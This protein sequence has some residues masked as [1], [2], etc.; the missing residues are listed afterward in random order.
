MKYTMNFIDMDHIDSNDRYSRT[1]FEVVSVKPLRASLLLR[2]H[3]RR[4]C[5]SVFADQLIKVI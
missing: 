5:L 4:E 1:E 3:G 2:F